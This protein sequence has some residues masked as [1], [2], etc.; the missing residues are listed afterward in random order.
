MSKTVYR[1]PFVKLEH[2]KTLERRFRRWFDAQPPLWR[3]RHGLELT[4]RSRRGVVT[5][6]VRLG[7]AY[8]LEG[9]SRAEAWSE[10]LGSLAVA[11]CIRE[12]D[13]LER[14]EEELRHAVFTAREIAAAKD[15]WELL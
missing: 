10:A 1:G 4:T 5:Y 15:E 9:S 7:K 13:A 8:G 6:R 12:A 14:K 2:H 11:T 3:K